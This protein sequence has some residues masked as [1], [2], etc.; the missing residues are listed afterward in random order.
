MESAEKGMGRV[1][2]AQ[3]LERVV[4]RLLTKWCARD[5]IN[6]RARLWHQRRNVSGRGIAKP[7][8]CWLHHVCR[9]YYTSH[10]GTHR[11]RNSAE[12]V[13]RLR[14]MPLRQLR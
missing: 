5:V 6:P 14:E 3:E 12:R 4:C 8:W 1:E 9:S 11:M 2:R 7:S 13:L 10:V